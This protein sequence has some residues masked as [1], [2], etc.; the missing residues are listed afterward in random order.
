M[1][2]RILEL[3]ANKPPLATHF[4]PWILPPTTIKAMKSTKSAILETA[5]RDSFAAAMAAVEREP[6]QTLLPTIA[7]TGTEYGDWEGTLE[8]CQWLKEK[9]ENQ[10][11]QVLDPVFLG[12]PQLW[13]MLCGKPLTTLFRTYGLCTPCINCHL[14][15]HMVRIPLARILNCNLLISG[16]REN[17]DGR[18]KVNQIPP[19]LDAFREFM[20][21]YGI[22]LLQPIRHLSSGQEIEELLGHR[23]QEGEEQVQCVL[24]GNYRDPGGQVNIPEEAVARL[25]R[26]YSFP[27]G[28]RM[29]R[30]RYGISPQPAPLG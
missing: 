23:W 28:E 1:D 24:S 12:D 5:G 22:N 13:H 19:V 20:A 10:G 27:Q 17:H 11:V 29:I 8:K 14:Y 6:I 2:P 7:Y 15:F 16:E 21:R 4:P 9:M 26:E 18:I 3:L 25:L 30:E